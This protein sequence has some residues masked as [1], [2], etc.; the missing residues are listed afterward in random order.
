MTAEQLQAG[1][2]R[3]TMDYYRIMEIVLRAL[4]Q[5]NAVA[6]ITRLIANV[7]RRVICVPKEISVYS[8]WLLRWVL[9]F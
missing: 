9:G 8:I 3:F 4:K 2:N 6:M 1:D 5:P 7:G